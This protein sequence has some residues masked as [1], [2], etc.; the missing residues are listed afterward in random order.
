[1]EI[2][3]RAGISD[4]TSIPLENA[5]GTQQQLE[6]EGYDVY[7]IPVGTVEYKGQFTIYL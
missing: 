2:G 5:K 4:M 6:N 3:H 7:R 1:M